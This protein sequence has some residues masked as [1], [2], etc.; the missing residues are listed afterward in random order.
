M[1]KLLLLYTLICTISSSFATITKQV[2]KDTIKERRDEYFKGVQ[3]VINDK[4]KGVSI[5]KP[6]K[7]L[8]EDQKDYY[9]S[10]IPERE[11]AQGINDS[12]F[13]SFTHNTDATYYLDNKKSSLSEILTQKREHYACGGSKRTGAVSSYYF[14][15]YPFFEKNIK[16]L[17]DH[18][19]NKIYAITILNESVENVPIEENLIPQPTYQRNGRTEDEGYQASVSSMSYGY[20]DE[21]KKRTQ[22]I[23]AHYPGGND[24]F[25]DYLFKTINVP[26]NLKQEEIVV[27]FII[28]TDGTLTD[29]F[30]SESMDPLLASEVKRAMQNSPRW[31]P[32]QKEGIP[33]QLG[34]RLYFKKNS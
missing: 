18:Y 32:A 22:E 17:N 30:L 5:N 14:Y 4:P 12:D 21:T 20:T 28:N 16:P 3:I 8:P 23:M 29:I 13:N 7:E 19:P 24:K 26:E 1:K 31:I 27:M 6:Y 9:L 10:Y 11:K 15:T 34:T 25:N 33:Y 2:H